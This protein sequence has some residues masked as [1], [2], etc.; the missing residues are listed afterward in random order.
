MSCVR[1]DFENNFLGKILMNSGGVGEEDGETG[2]TV[3]AM[4]D[5]SGRDQG[6]LDRGRASLMW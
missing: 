1:G 4:S 2:L 3:V 6:F 5:R